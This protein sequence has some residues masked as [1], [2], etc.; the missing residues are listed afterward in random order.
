MFSAVA[1][2]HQAA[3]LERRRCGWC[4]EQVRASDLLASNACGCCGRRLGVGGPVDRGALLEQV[5]AGWSRWRWPVYGGILLGSVLG[6]MLPLVAPVFFALSMV[7]VHLFI[8]RRPLTWLGRGRRLS[9]RLTLKLALAG[10]TFVN[11]VFSTLLFSVFGCGQLV[12]GIWAVVSSVMY[13]EG[14]LWLVGNRLRREAESQGLDFWEVALPVGIL[15][16][17]LVSAGAS[18]VGILAVAHVLVSAEI[19]GV[20]AIASFLLDQGGV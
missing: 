2:I 6:S 9:A 8:V 10:L 11:L 7:L 17:L 18:V 20:S 3:L 1:P 14:A 4:A 12:I 5:Q 13:V 15:G 19:P 16:G